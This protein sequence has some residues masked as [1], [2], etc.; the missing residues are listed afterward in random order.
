M[1]AIAETIG[2]AILPDWTKDPEAVASRFSSG[3]P[4]VKTSAILRLAAELDIALDDAL[5]RL[6]VLVHEEKSP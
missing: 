5:R 4:Y 1:T 2:Y 6:A 3:S